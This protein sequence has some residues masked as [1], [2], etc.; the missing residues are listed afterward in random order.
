MN[1]GGARRG[2]SLA[3]YVSR[4][5]T[6][7]DRIASVLARTPGVELAVLF[8]STARGTARSN[9]DI[10]VALRGN[11]DRLTLAAE[12]SRECGREV[13]M[14]DLDAATIPLTQAIL[15]DGQPLYEARRGAYG[16][17]RARAM[18][19]LETDLPGYRRMRD[20][21]LKRLAEGR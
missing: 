11:C 17:W 12:I 18:M 21:Y 6:L 14:V 13:D 19:T 15:R 16:E 10:D 3:W 7:A 9:S 8:G 1:P 20:A 5:G 2:R 4:V